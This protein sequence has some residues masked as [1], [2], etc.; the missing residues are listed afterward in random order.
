MDNSVINKISL[1]HHDKVVF[2]NF[3]DIIFIQAN[4]GC[5]EIGTID[6]QKLYSSKELKMYE[7][8]FKGYDDL[9]RIN[10]SWIINLKYIKSYSKG[11]TCFI[12]LTSGQSLEVPRR[13]KAEI[14]DKIKSI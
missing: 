8:V 4:N 3:E 9:L 1:H 2:V 14:L 7:N 5:C 13:K 6:N 10:K 12:E 11:E